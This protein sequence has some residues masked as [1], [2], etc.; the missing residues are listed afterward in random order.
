MPRVTEE[1]IGRVM[2]HFR[3]SQEGGRCDH[4][5]FEWSMP[6]SDALELVATSPARTRALLGQRWE[7]ARKRHDPPLWSP[8]AYVWHMA[9]AIGIWSERLV[10]LKAEPDAPLVGFDQDLLAEVRSYDQLSPIA[11]LWAYE[12]RVQD[13]TES[14][15]LQE[16]ST[17]FVH[18][19]FGPWTIGDVIKWMSHDMYHHEEDIR[20]Q[21]S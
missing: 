5:G 19:D 17:A 7:D 13:F 21:M 14:A 8:S 12:R 16:P 20:R 15:R 18:P 10:A 9:D 3:T 6:V 4:C 1:E 2:G 11:A